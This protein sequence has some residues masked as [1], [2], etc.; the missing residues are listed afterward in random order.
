MEVKRAAFAKSTMSNILTVWNRYKQFCAI[1]EVQEVPISSHSLSLFA[2]YLSDQVKSPAT[3]RNYLS[4]IRTWALI[5]GIQ[6]PTASDAGLQ[7]TIKGLTKLMR[8]Q[9]KQAAPMTPSI[10]SQIRTILELHDSFQLAVWS[11]LLLGFFLFLRSSNLVPKSENSFDT[12]KQLTVDDI[13]MDGSAMLVS[14]NWS[15]TIQ[16]AERVLEIP[17]LAMPGSP[18]CPVTAVAQLLK[19]VPH[20][21]GSPLLSYTDTFGNLRVLT[22]GQLSRSLKVL[23]QSVGLHPSQF[24]THSLRRG[25]ATFAFQSGVQGEAIQK[26]GDW[27]SDCYKRYLDSTLEVRVSVAHTVKRSILSQKS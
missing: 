6:A 22:Y 12:T 1:A 27:S 14:I 13:R 4:I 23:V 5:H 26:M 7:Y 21:K 16:S 24:T 25:G 17:L 20:K 15:K 3:I 19:S 8:H 10:L 9:P 11:A 2:V 18:L